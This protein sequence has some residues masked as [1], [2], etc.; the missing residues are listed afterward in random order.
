MPATA[1]LL[2]NLALPLLLPVPCAVFQGVTVLL[3]SVFHFLHVVGFLRLYVLLQGV[4]LL[5][6]KQLVLEREVFLY[7]LYFVK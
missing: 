7:S 1:V 5:F 6:H 3:F 4:L 2:E